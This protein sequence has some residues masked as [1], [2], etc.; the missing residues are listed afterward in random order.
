MNKTVT[1][2]VALLVGL[3]VGIPVGGRWMPQENTQA[4]TTAPANRSF[5]AVP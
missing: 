2:G 1:I 3:L 4:A 5:S